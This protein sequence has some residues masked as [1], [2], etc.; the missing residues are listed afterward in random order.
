MAGNDFIRHM[1][2]QVVSYLDKPRDQRKQIRNSR[3]GGKQPF[4]TK[5]FGILPFALLMIFKKND[6]KK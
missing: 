2:Q 1:T 4:L 3:K 6:K 5:W